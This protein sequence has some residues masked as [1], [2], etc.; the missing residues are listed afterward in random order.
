MLVKSHI[1]AQLS[2]EGFSMLQDDYTA[3]GKLARTVLAELNCQS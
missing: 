2:K 3:L 1:W